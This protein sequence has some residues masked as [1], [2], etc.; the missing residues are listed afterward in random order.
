MEL[1]IYTFVD[2]TPDPATGRATSPEQRV[3]NLMEEIELADQVG[4]FD[5]RLAQL[6]AS[7][8]PAQRVRAAW[9]GARVG[10][11]RTLDALA[12]ALG[13]PDAQLRMAGIWAFEHRGERERAPL[14]RPLLDDP[15]FRVREFAR[16][17]LARLEG[18][19]P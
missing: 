7:G 6:I 9:I 17:A 4:G 11:P 8:L 16:R 19:E 3:R 18:G 2:A 12:F 14:I 15:S 1:G 10:G 5:R 13:N